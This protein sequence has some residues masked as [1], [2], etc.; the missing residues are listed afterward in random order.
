MSYDEAIG[1]AYRIAADADPLLD[2]PEREQS[3]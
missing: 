3:P 2:Q 1:S